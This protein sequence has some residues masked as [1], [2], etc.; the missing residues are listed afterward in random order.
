MA[1]IT[2]DPSIGLP[3]NSP[4]WLPLGDAHRLLCPLLGE[5]HLAAKD[6]RD[7]MADDRDRRVRSMRRC[8]ARGIRRPDE[9]LPASY[10][11]EHWLDPRSDGVFVM[12]GFRSIATVKGYAFFVWKPDLA[13]IWPTI[14]PPTPAPPPPTKQESSPPSSSLPS[15]LAQELRPT[16]V[17]LTEELRE[18][19]PEEIAETAP[20]VPTVLPNDPAAILSLLG[21]KGFQQQAIA[22]AVRELY[23]REPPESLTAGKL[24]DDVKNLQKTKA[25]K[26]QARGDTPLR[27]PP[28][29]DACNNFV[30]ALRAWRAKQRTVDS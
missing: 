26:A 12:E 14:F 22:E 23:G 15:S 20:A 21:L 19:R 1:G 8:F 28:G 3:L 13:K 18:E 11:V 30:Q 2:D 25:A 29:W 9:L 10:W 7:A 24:R 4:N 17:T 27:R 6:L 16:P 5:K